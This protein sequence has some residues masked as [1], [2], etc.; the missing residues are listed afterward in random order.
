MSPPTY[1]S[2]LLD[3]FCDPLSLT[4]SSQESMGMGL[5]TET[6]GTH[7]WL[8][9]WRQYLPFSK[10]LLKLYNYQEEPGP[11]VISSNRPDLSTQLFATP[12]QGT[13]GCKSPWLQCSCHAQYMQTCHVF[14]TY[15]KVMRFFPVSFAMLSGPW[16]GWY[17]D[18]FRTSHSTAFFFPA[19]WDVMG[20]CIHS[21][22]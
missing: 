18:L 8:H 12:V 11:C 10:H 22:K 4:W 20:F 21:L 17:S 5:N 3:F 1:V 6:W 15:H 9:H 16:G 2:F 13:R 14:P 19:P 7:Q